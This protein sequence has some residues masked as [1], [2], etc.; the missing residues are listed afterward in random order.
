MSALQSPP[1]PPPAGTQIR[2]TGG[3]SG[4]S[5]PLYEFWILYPGG[6]WVLAQAYSSSPTF[7]W[8]TSGQPAGSYRI[9]V[10]ARDAS[11]PG[12]FGT[13]PNKYDAVSGF[14]DRQSVV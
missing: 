12:T 14:P 1:S 8:T 7:N 13:S 4:C 2:I 3:A 11:S 9:S 6:P 10:W 5:N